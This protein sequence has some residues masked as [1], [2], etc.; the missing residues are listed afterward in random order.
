M[1]VQRLQ[2]LQKLNL[3]GTHGGSPFAVELTF[4]GLPVAKKESAACSQVPIAELFVAKGHD[5]INANR[6]PGGDITRRECD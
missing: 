4:F 3:N 1:D 5:R 2:M 6:T